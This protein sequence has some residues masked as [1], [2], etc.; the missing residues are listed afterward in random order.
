MVLRKQSREV[1]SCHRAIEIGL[2]RSG[3][4]A[5]IALRRRAPHVVYLA[6]HDEDSG[7]AWV[8][9][10][11]FAVWEGNIEAQ[12]SLV[13]QRTAL[14]RLSLNC[15]SIAHST[16]HTHTLFFPRSKSPGPVQSR[17]P[18]GQRRMLPTRRSKI[19]RCGS[20]PLQARVSRVS[21]PPQLVS[22]R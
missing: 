18:S 3:A 19:A 1:P 11:V 9:S 2:L 10:E 13:W 14:L 21:A 20:H 7:A 6:L 16:Q 4:G 17:S 8:V 5:E 12:L 15:L 22:L